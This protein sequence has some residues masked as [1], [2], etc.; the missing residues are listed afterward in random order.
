VPKTLRRIMFRRWCPVN[1]Q[2]VAAVK[3]GCLM[4]HTRAPVSQLLRSW[5]DDN[6]K[7]VVVVISLTNQFCCSNSLKRVFQQPR[8]FSTITAP[9]FRVM[10]KERSYEPSPCDSR[11]Q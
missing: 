4:D 7:R 3:P 9:T 1:L 2:I 11:S 5:V 6:L 10:Q 8:L